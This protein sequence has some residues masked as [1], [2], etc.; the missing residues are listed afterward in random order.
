MVHLA[1]LAAILGPAATIVL[2]SDV[3]LYNSSPVVNL[4]NG[5]YLGQQNVYY[6][7]DEFLGIPYAQPP[8]GNLRF[9]APVSLNTTWNYTKPA[10]S[11]SSICVGYGSDS[12]FYESSEDC[13]TINIVR[14]TGV[15]AN[16]SLP[17]VLWLYGGGFYE[18]GTVDPRYNLSRIV[19]KGVEAEKPII[20]ISINYRLSAFGFLWSN[21]VKANGTGNVGL[22]DQRLAMHW[23]QENIAAFGGDPAKV[24]LWGESAGG[25]AIGRHLIAYGGR[26]DQL[27]RGAIMESGGPLERWP[28][29]VPNSDEYSEELYQNL[30][31]STG[32]TNASIPLECLRDLPFAKLNAA[33]NITDTWIAGTGLG[34]WVS[35]IDNDF[36]VDYAST[37][38]DDGR[39]VRVPILYGTN[40]DEGTAI[41]PSGVNT[42]AEFAAAVAQGG[43]DNATIQMV[44]SLYPNVDAL[45][46]PL[47]YN[48]TASDYETYGTQWKRIAAFFGDAVEHYPRRTVTQTWAK[49]NLTAYSY[50]FN[51]KPYGLSN[52]IGVTHFQE[53]AW[54]F[55]NIYGA[56]YSTDP[57]GNNDAAYTSVSTLMSRMWVSFVHDLNPNGHG[58]P[59]YPVWPQYNAKTGGVGYNYVFDANVTSYVEADDW[60]T[61]GMAFIAE[62]ARSQWK[63]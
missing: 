38:I 61:P 41:G 31:D 20:A 58:L 5:S 22:R 59:G 36:L 4:K 56:G 16:Q 57:F 49:N 37:Q 55:N 14:P 18:G 2:A 1:R 13:L 32:C 15:N 6:N 27:F 54:V 40:T 51:V 21:E 11:Y 12:N 45:G 33:L 29:A 35:V 47:G 25:I 24:T 23:I 63:H 9:R 3:S 46:I 30:T 60:R 10:T 53:V 17:V 50:R 28:Y 39:F 48:M 42:D 44:E 7:Q 43:P 19:Q 52:V 8:V 26:D 62:N 34:P